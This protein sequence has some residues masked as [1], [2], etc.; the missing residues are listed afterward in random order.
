[1]KSV[2]IAYDQAHHEHII[3]ILG[4]LNCRGFTSFGTV[5][6]LSLIHI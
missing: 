6:G 1:M 5:Q 2:F 3:E 4:H